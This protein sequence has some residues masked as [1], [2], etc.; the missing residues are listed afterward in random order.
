MFAGRT[1]EVSE[2]LQ[3]KFI[4]FSMDTGIL[5][6]NIAFLPK[7]RTFSSSHVKDALS[8]CV[9]VNLFYLFFLLLQR[10]VPRPK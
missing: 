8:F 5:A 1:P 9:L 10:N 2:A 4:T 3:Q 6:D 7:N